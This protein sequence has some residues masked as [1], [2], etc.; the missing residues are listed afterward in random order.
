MT[1]LADLDTPALVLDR[2]RLERN[3]E[4][5]SKRMSEAGV[6]LRPHLKTAKSANVAKTATRG[7]FG[8]VT[9]STLAEARYFLAQGISDLTYAVGL[10][11]GKLDAV[12]KLQAQGAQITLLTDSMETLKAA[13]QKAADLD[14]DFR[15]LIE[16]DTG[17]LRGGVPPESDLLIELGRFLNECAGLTLAGV[18]THA[19]HSYHCRNQAEIEQVAEEE[20]VGA[21]LA[22]Q[23]LRDAGLTCE[24]VSAG[25]TPTAICAKSLEGLTEMRPGVYTFFDLDQMALGV[26]AMEDI[27]LSVVATVI[28]HNHAAG[29]ILIDAGGLALSKDLSAA[30]FLEHAGYGL[31]CPL[32]MTEPMDGIYVESVHQE[33]GLIAAVGGEPPYDKLPVGARVRILPNHACMTAAAYDSYHVVDGGQDVVD[34]WGRVNGWY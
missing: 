14:T 11:A 24:T 22:A 9:V 30:E 23:R 2:S 18:L 27:A 32:D 16:V 17:G 10:A 26:C 6:R 4:R 15:F 3:C 12:A 13:A 21:V 33:H 29:R 5:M 28:G 19:G 25:S 7:H 8:G 34:A 1:S 20:R 31:V